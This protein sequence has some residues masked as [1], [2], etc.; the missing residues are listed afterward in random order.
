MKKLLF[1]LLFLLLP[2]AMSLAGDSPNMKPGLW[3]ITTK[4]HMQGMNLPPSTV[5]QCLTED[6]MVPS[7]SQPG[8][9]CEV[10]DMKTSGNTVTWTMKCTSG[11]QKVKS[12]GSVE[13]YGTSFKGTVTTILEDGMEIESAMTGKRLG[14]CK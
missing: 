13:Y 5:T 9:E 4:T 3:E 7:S 1:F 11:G 14:D 8:Q 6:D 12:K 10:I 2:A